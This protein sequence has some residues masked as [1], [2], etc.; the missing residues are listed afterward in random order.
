[1]YRGLEFEYEAFKELNTCRQ[2]EGLRSLPWTAINEY[3]RQHGLDDDEV[4]DFR[5]LMRAMDEVWLAHYQTKA[6]D[7]RRAAETK[8]RT[9]GRK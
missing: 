8:A 1:L 6:K 5:L 9:K 4:E 3:A 2:G 7:E